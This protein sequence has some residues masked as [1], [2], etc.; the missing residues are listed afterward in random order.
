MD[1]TS[2]EKEYTQTKNKINTLNKYLKA[3]R[4]KLNEIAKN[5][6]NNEDTYEFKTNNLVLRKPTNHLCKKGVVTP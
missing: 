6:L 3:N 2:L 5:L 4:Q 1:Y